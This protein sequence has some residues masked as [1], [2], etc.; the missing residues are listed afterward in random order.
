[1]QFKYRWINNRFCVDQRTLMA[2]TLVP[3][4]NLL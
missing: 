2:T 4:K 1:M 3:Y